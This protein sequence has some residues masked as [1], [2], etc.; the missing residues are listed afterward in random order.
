MGI[1]I[2]SICLVISAAASGNDDVKKHPSCQYCGMDREK[3]SHSRVYI[4][5][6]DGTSTGACSLH[7]AALD[8]ALNI[9]KSPKTIMVGDYKT[10]NLIDAEK[11]SWVMGG[12]KPGVMTRRAKWA[13]ESKAEAEAFIKENSGTPLVFDEAM[14]AAYED[15]YQ[16][17]KMIREKR[18]MMR[19]KQMEGK[20]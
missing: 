2:F 16:D 1:I 13:F 18:K 19:M 14:K 10:K 9:D 20:Q 11:A 3:F 8:I 7:C 5:Y 15:M 6:D 17:T 12:N 4:E